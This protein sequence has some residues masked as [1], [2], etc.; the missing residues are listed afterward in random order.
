M[1]VC[2]W[3]QQDMWTATTCTGNI[4]FVID[5]TTYAPIPAEE[6]CGGCGVNRG[7]L[8]HPGCDIEKCPRCDGQR[9]H[10]NCANPE[11]EACHIKMEYVGS[12]DR[13]EYWECPSCGAEKDG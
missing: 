2:E 8:H 13:K 5:G 11:C 7:G 4:P 3:C 6:D 10:C 9:V 1:R 12:D